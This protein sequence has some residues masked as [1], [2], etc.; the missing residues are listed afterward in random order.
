MGNLTMRVAISLDYS[1]RFRKPV[2]RVVELGSTGVDVVLVAEAYSFGAVS[3]LGYLAAR[4]STIELGSG[5][6]PIYPRT[7]SLLAITAADWM[8]DGRF[9]LGIG[10]S[11]P[12]V[13]EGFHGLAFDAPRGR[14]RE[15]VDICRQVW[16]RN[17]T[18]TGGFDA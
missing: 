11:G 6:F 12:Q 7:P 3:Q 8:S 13:I 14:T 9:W 18:R 2:D 16:R 5:V 15:V 10:T 1:G 4:T 17:R